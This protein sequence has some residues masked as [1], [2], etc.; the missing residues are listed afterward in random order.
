MLTKNPCMHPADIRVV[1][2]ISDTEVAE[3]FKNKNESY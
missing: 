1:N 2:C 3:R